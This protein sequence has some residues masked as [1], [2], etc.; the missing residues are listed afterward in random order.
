VG[1]LYRGRGSDGWIQTN[2]RLAAGKGVY[3]LHLTRLA[4]PIR[5][6]LQKKAV[7]E[8]SLWSVG[9]GWS[10]VARN[11]EPSTSTERGREGASEAEMYVRESP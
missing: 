11:N 4:L 10:D 7:A 3:P 6:M 8:E 2:P 9:G 5:Y 1:D